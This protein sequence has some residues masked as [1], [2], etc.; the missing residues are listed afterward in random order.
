MR[1]CDPPGVSGERLH[2]RRTWAQRSS[3]INIRGRLL[4]TQFAPEFAAWRSAT[5]CSESMPGRP[6]D[7]ELERRLLAAAWGRLTE[8]SYAALTLI[9]VA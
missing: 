5:S 9:Q 3:D 4:R 7:R 1:T 6:R 2:F 8:D